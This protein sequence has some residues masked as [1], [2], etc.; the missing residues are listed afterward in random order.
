[1]NG[2]PKAFTLDRNAKLEI[3][4]LQNAETPLNIMSRT[5]LQPPPPLIT[6]G[7]SA[8][9]YN[10]R[11]T[12]SLFNNL[13]N[14]TSTTS[15][16]SE[17]SSISKKVEEMKTS[18]TKRKKP[19][20]LNFKKTHRR[21]RSCPN[22]IKT[23]NFVNQ[24][25]AHLETLVGTVNIP[26][27]NQQTVTTNEFKQQDHI[28]SGTCGNVYRTQLELLDRSGHKTC[29]TVATKEMSKSGNNEELKRILQDVAVYHKC[30]DCKFI[31]QWYGVLDEQ[32]TIYIIMEY[33]KYGDFL[34]IIKKV[35]S[36]HKLHTSNL[37]LVQFIPES[38]ILQFCKSVVEAL[39][40]LK[41]VHQIIHRDIR[42]SNILVD[43][44][45]QIKVCDFS[46]AG[47]LQNS[48]AFTKDA[49]VQAYLAPERLDG[50]DQGY[51]VRSDIFA[52]GLTIYEVATGEYAVK[53][54][55][56][57]QIA[58]EIKTSK[59]SLPAKN[60]PWTNNFLAFYTACLAKRV[61]V[62]PKPDQLRTYPFIADKDYDKNLVKNYLD[63]M[64]GFVSNHPQ[65]S[66]STPSK[67]P[68]SSVQKSQFVIE[69]PA[70]SSTSDWVTFD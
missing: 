31:V 12:D 41:N 9:I 7:S 25:L 50:L 28:G 30:R 22:E 39:Y 51:D 29:K 27:Y 68:Q 18:V 55:N 8:E 53:S 35:D 14:A 20:A 23:I 66:M 64:Y 58:I 16:Q 52:L 46:I 34:N 10:P 38:I 61:D 47:N 36:Y 17:L 70:A 13:S 24:G 63:R 44:S 6:K 19:G 42:P 48:I 26:G 1:M 21:I 57:M 56:P 49:G 62:R 11:K 65:T 4:N 60:P 45:G 15:V 54:R 5:C 59:F 69:T 67:F 40:Y 2:Q 43:P 32:E 3:N 33:C 37:N